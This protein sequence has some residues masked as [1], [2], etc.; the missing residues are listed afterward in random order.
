MQYLRKEPARPLGGSSSSS[1]DGS[2][3]EVLGCPFL[4]E[5]TDRFILVLGD[6]QCVKWYEHTV[7]SSIVTLPKGVTVIGTSLSGSNPASAR[8]ADNIKNRFSNVVSPWWSNVS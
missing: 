8:Q 1:S 3:G 5:I 4:S 6:T 2:V 7:H